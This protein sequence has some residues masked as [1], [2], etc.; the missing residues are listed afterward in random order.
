MPSTEDHLI[1][2]IIAERRLS[3]RISNT[4]IQEF[5]IRMAAPEREKNGDYRCSWEFVAPGYRKVRSQ[6]GI[7]G[8]QAIHLANR[9]IGV[10]LWVIAQEHGYHFTWE[11]SDDIGFSEFHA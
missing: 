1:G 3:A 11:G 2:P 6:T 10:T 8:F 4:E 7:D 5:I 9:M